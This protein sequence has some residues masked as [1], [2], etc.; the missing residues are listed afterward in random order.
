MF[1]EI[2]LYHN[3]KAYIVSACIVD[4]VSVSYFIKMYY[5][6]ITGSPMLTQKL[7]FSRL[8]AV[9]LI[10]ITNFIVQIIVLSVPSRP[11]NTD[12]MSNTLKKIEKHTPDVLI[13]ESAPLFRTDCHPCYVV[14]LT[15]IKRP[16]HLVYM[17]CVTISIQD[18]ALLLLKMLMASKI[19]QLKSLTALGNV[20]GI[21]MLT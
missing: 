12:Q 1:N 14:L 5:I 6:Y 2:L 21:K 3:V 20:G 15:K 10:Y 7:F 13:F 4:T 17:S 9:L 8:P 11:G 19:C 18:V 16:G